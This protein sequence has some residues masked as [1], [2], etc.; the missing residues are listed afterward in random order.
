MALVFR[1]SEYLGYKISVCTYT[2]KVFC[3]NGSKLF[4]ALSGGGYLLILTSTN[5][6]LAIASRCV[7]L[8][9]SN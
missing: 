9:Q 8:S 2:L 3:V 1:R 5:L 7:L 6:L 4:W